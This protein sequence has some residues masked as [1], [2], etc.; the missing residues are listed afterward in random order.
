MQKF[1]QLPTTL[2]IFPL[3]NVALLPGGFLPLNIFEPR[4]LNMLQDAMG[5]HH[6]IGMI[7]PRDENPEPE[8]YQIGC[9]GRIVGYQETI[10]GRLEIMLKG[11]CRFQIKEEL[12]SLRGYRLITPDWSQFA[13]DYEE[14]PQPDAQAKLSFNGALRACFN[15]NQMTVDWETLDKLNT[16]DLMNNLFTS[17]P[18]KS[19][20]KQLLLE[21]DTLINRIKIFTAILEDNNNKTTGEDEMLF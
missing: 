9:A 1:E 19:E 2:P 8:L 21:T 3:P 13:M 5:S 12:S 20:D 16:E 11:L 6:L 17:L 7:Q 14:Q 18:L 15:Q 4:Y 10:D